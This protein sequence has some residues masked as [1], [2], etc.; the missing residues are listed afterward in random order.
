[1]KVN[2]LRIGNFVHSIPKQK[3]FQVSIRTLRNL[4]SGKCY[5]EPIKISE[6]WLRKFGFSSEPSLTGKRFYK[7]KVKRKNGYQRSAFK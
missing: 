2:E 7:N 3:V 5:I 1:M 6:E 4:Q